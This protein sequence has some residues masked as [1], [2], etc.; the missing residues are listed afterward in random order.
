MSDTFDQ[1]TS[2]AH[3]RAWGLRNWLNRQVARPGFQSVISKTPG[4]SRIARKEGEALFDLVA[5]F[6]NS[7]VLSALVE[8][9]ICETLLEVG[10]ASPEALAHGTGDI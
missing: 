2:P 1:L 5:G 9:E 8:L 6:V 7:Q 10:H 3:R 4:L